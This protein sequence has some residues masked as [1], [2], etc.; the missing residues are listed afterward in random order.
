MNSAAPASADLHTATWLAAGLVVLP[1]LQ[2]LAI[3]FDHTGALV[4]LLPALWAGRAR[5][6]EAV[7]QLVAGPAWLKFS[8]AVATLAIVCSV[9]AADQPAPATV[10]AAEWALLGAIGLIAGRIARVETRAG[11]RILEGLAVGA[12]G[13]MI[14]MWTL[15]WLGGRGAVPLYAHYRHPGLHA[16]SG[17]LAGVALAASANSKRARLG[18]FAIGGFA[19]AGLL[20]TG[21][22]ASMLAL[23]VAV[24]AWI[25]FAP[26]ASRKKLFVVSAQQLVF[27]LLFSLAMWTT[28]P[29]RGWWHA[30]TR[31]AEAA[32]AGN[33]R[34]LTSKRSE[35]WLDTI[36][37][38]EAR[39]WLG[40]GLDAYRFLTP[41]LDGQQPHNLIL[42][43]W[44]D[45]GVLGTVP[46][47]M[48]LAG[49]LWLGGRRAASAAAGEPLILVW[50]AILLASG[51]AG[52]FDG[53][54]YH[55]LAFLPA[56]LALGVTVG[57]LFEAPRTP[58][59]RWRA[60][61]I[62]ATALAIGVLAL[63]S[64][65]FYAVAIDLPPETG[66]LRA[67][68]VRA[69][70]S[71]TFALS[72]WLDVWQTTQPAVALEWTRW[73][74]DH[75]PNAPF[76]HVYAA[77]QLLARG[78]RAGAEAEL[79]AALAKAHWTARP[80]IESMLQSL[81]PAPP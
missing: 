35:F 66:S 54:F 72:R 42:Q 38:A 48:I 76:F 56:A 41:K 5:L 52:M 37:R 22:R 73:A 30:F 9:A 27:G 62:G 45:V 70:P 77:Q 53:V 11:R 75:A 17:A 23:G 1:Y 34:E 14:A 31:T 19:W 36:H 3:D 79:R 39:P 68:I 25:Y 44:L 60:P 61:V 28:S 43:F 64:W 26:A 58:T 33:V 50:P 13:G 47:L 24:V 78:D 65:I 71:S 15:W 59:I 57:F 74:E 46:L 20:W 16:L 81:P 63:H 51:A 29:E 21:G 8:A 2:A 18:W 10:T 7:N 6:V 49:V 69:F 40:H 12:A 67:R 4:V 55:L 80:T 32:Q